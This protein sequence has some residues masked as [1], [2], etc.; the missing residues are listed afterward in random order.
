MSD[1]SISV[2]KRKTHTHTQ[3]KQTLSIELRWIC[4]LLVEY[5][6]EIHS[7]PNA[8]K[9][10]L[11]SKSLSIHL[12]VSSKW[13]V[14]RAS[15]LLTLVLMR[16]C[17]LLLVTADCILIRIPWSGMAGPPDKGKESK[18]KCK[19]VESAGGPLLA[20]GLYRKALANF[21]LELSFVLTSNPSPSPVD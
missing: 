15:P 19:E 4:F 11:L 8:S 12:I 3:T 20:T 13:A 7:C 5:I 14:I 18:R 2:G 17:S 21:V 6:K 9:K 10:W 1:E 16:L